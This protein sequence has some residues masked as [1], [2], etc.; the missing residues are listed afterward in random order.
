[1]KKY[2]KNVVTLAKNSMV[3]NLKLPKDLV[4]GM[5]ILTV[6]G[7]EEAFIENYKGILECSN[8]CIVVQTKVCRI[9][10]NGKNLAVAYYIEN[11][12]KI[13]GQMEQIIY[14]Q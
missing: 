12:M 2:K 14:L 8:E 7:S 10:I 9:Q 13:I 6:T 1:M 11:E 3:E 5:P 4:M